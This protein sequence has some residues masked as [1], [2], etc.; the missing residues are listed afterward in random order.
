M[1]SNPHIVLKNIVQKNLLMVK[2]FCCLD[3]QAVRAAGPAEGEEP[4]HQ[5]GGSQP[6]AS[7]VTTTY[8]PCRKRENHNRLRSY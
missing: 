3:A 6:G 8:T 1:G 2:W 4:A 5:P 7:Q